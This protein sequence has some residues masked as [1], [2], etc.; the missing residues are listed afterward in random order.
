MQTSIN[1]QASLEEKGHKKSSSFLTHSLAII[2]VVCT[3]FVGLA[4][5]SQKNKFDPAWDEIDSKAA[6]IAEFEGGQLYKQN[7]IHIV[8]LN[9]TFHE[10]GRQYGHLLKEQINW[11]FD[12]L[13]KDFFVTP[14]GNPVVA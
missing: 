8:V 5:A 4:D 7:A 11:H 14:A 10:M 1:H 6:K 9:G 13:K 2:A 3:L 12:E